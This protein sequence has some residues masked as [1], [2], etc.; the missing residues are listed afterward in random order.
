MEGKERMRMDR[1]AFSRRVMAM[2]GRLYRISC[3]M[4]SNPQDRMDAVQETVLKAWAHVD[5]LREERY[6]ETW[7][8]RI[9]INT[10]HDFQSSGRN[11][12]P[13][14]AVAE[15]AAAERSFADLR[16]ALNALNED[17]RIPVL[18]QYMEGYRHREIAVILNIPVGTVKSRIARAKRELRA[19]LEEERA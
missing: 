1:Q 13:L 16:D 10:C 15:P 5:R 12:V 9:L 7:L 6:F 4:L 18:L 3:G 14:E 8:T 17:L 19:L 2:E 11:C